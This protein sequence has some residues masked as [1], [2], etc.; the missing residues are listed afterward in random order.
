MPWPL[1][2]PR[3][4]HD[5][6][7]CSSCQW[8]PS[9]LVSLSTCA[10]VIQELTQSDQILVSWVTNSFPRP[11]V[12]RSS[13]IA[14]CNMIGNTASIYGS[15]MYPAKDEP[16]FVPGGSA[17]AVICLLVAALAFVL[18]L[19]HIRE[20]KKLELAEREARPGDAEVGDTDPELRAMGFRYIL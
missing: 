7:P 6:S 9:V 8:V 19:I 10:T 13:A 12:K 15:Y 16:Q 11:L 17:N 14:I 1:E 20:N 4:A 3:P 2:R 18:R 5:S